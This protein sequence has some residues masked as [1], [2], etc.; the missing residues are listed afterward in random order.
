[1]FLKMKGLSRAVLM[2]IIGSPN[3]DRSE[4]GQKWPE[5]LESAIGFSDRKASSATFSQ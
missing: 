5:D 2:S 3:F 1:M 4:V